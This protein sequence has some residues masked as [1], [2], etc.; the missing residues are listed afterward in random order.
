MLNYIWAGLILFAL[1]FALATDVGDLRHHA[2]ANGVP[3]PATVEY[4]KLDDVN[5][6]DATVDLRISQPEYAQHFNVSEN[7]AT[8]F[9]VTLTKMDHGYLLRFA[10]DAPLPPRMAAMR[11]FS[12]SKEL[13]ANVDTVGAVNDR[14]VADDRVFVEHRAG[15]NEYIAP[16][17]ATGQDLSAGQNCCAVANFAVVADRYARVNVNILAAAG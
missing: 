14:A 16:D 1:I 17:L 4:R 15:A 7:L 5:A 3:L 11:D 2:Y 6:R 10:K 9:P 13:V 12:D 8:S